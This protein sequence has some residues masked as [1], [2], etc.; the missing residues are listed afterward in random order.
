MPDSDLRASASMTAEELIAEA[1]ERLEE[2]RAFSQEALEAAK[3]RQASGELLTRQ[4]T[5]ALNRCVQLARYVA[6]CAHRTIHMKTRPV[7]RRRRNPLA[8]FMQGAG[9]AEGSADGSKGSRP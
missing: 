6:D 1:R 5:R 2:L 8:W 7:E 3:A 9:A 4:D